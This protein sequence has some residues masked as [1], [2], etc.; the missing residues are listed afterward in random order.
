[1]KLMLLLLERSAVVSNQVFVAV[2][3]GVKRSR[4]L[5]SSLLTSSNC[6]AG[7]GLGLEVG[8]I[9]GMRDQG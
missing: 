3:V 5:L 8:K 9:R 4:A 6:I 7:S 2:L 1:M